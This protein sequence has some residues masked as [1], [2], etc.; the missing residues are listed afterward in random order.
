MAV[1][2]G[3]SRGCVSGD[4][5]PSRAEEAV[6]LVEVAAA[7]QFAVPLGERVAFLRTAVFHAL[8]VPVGAAGDASQL[9]KFP[10]I[11]C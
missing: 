11:L 6:E 3:T 7:E 9:F 5:S 8:E 4:A 10:R 2:G 1:G